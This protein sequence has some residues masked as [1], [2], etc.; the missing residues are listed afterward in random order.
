MTIKYYKYHLP[1]ADSLRTSK[2]T[3]KNREGFIIE[4]LTEEFQCYGEAAPLPEYSNETLD[5]VQ[6]ILG[7]IKDTFKSKLGTN[8][9]TEWLQDFYKEKKIP[10]SLQFGL[11]S[12]AYQIQAYRSD[13]SLKN[14]LFPEAPIKIPIN[15]LSSLTLDN[16]LED[17]ES[18][19][20][21]GFRTIKYKVGIDFELEFHRLQRLRAHFPDLTFRV[22]AN[23]AW[24]LEEAY[25]N[26][27]KMVTLNIEYC[28]EPLQRP[29]PK[30]FKMLSNNTKLPL[31]LDESLYQVSYW[32]SLLPYT[33]CLIL[34]PMLLG[35]FTKNFE[36]KHL[37]NTHDNEVV[38]TTSLESGIGR[39]ITAIIAS[40]KGTAQAAHGLNTGELLAKDIYSD[41]P[42][43]SNGFYHLDRLQGQPD[44]TPYELKE[45][46]SKLFR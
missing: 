5:D 3:F 43:I 31:A 35:S 29:T 27:Q 23:Q 24:S 8:Q 21:K 46:S 19:L 17:A 34:K 25:R 15:A 20:K 37:A 41:V 30:N 22:D 40:G 16:Y 38:F 2:M 9:S 33:S 18:H 1:F 39:R 6:E 13:K 42:C 14:Y 45:V 26:C 36:T 12:I 10:A 32:P 44:E 4:Y 7:S 28:E 11:D